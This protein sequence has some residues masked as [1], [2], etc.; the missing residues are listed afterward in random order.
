MKRFFLCIALCIF[1]TFSNAQVQFVAVG[2]NNSGGSPSI[3]SFKSDGTSALL[4][5]FKISD[6]TYC[7]GITEG[8]DGKL[9]GTTTDGGSDN[10]GVIF[11]INPDGTN[12]KVIFNY[13][14]SSKRPHPS[15]GPDGKLYITISDSLYSMLPDGSSV[16]N[17]AV[18]GKGCKEIVVSNDSWVYGCGSENN[19]RFIFR[20][21]TDGSGYTVLHAFNRLTE[22]NL[23]VSNTTVCITPTGRVFLTCS[24]SVNN[25]GTLISIRT[26]GSDLE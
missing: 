17:I 24:G 14:T 8:P 16:K 21:K 7:Q 6:P 5:D 4:H 26:D 20:I 3:V 10:N 9:Y 15:F 18:V 22:G 25:K 13:A 11:S 19:S 2:K 23:D 1:S 12:F